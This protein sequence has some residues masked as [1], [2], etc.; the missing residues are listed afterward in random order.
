MR[1]CHVEGCTSRDPAR[2]VFHRLPT[3]AKRRAVW[4]RA[5][6]DDAEDRVAS[7]VC[8]KH[9]QKSSYEKDLKSLKK[10]AVPTLFLPVPTSSLYQV[11][12]CPP[13]PDLTTITNRF[14][15]TLIN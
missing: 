11:V 6:G 7:F 13:C 10:D 2:W 4:T 5:C 1:N 9:F 14:V 3:D 15:A 12:S 8:S